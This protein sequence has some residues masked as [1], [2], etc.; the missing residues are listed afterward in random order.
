MKTGALFYGPLLGAGVSR[1]SGGERERVMTRG[2]WGCI[3]FKLK[4]YTPRP[5]KKNSGGISYFPPDPLET[6]KGGPLP[7]F[8]NPPGGR[9]TRDEGSARRVVVPYGSAGDE[10]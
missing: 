10:R 7:P 4:E 9:G 8:G 5:P 6:T 3:L 1:R 2:I